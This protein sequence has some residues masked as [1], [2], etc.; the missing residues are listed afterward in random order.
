MIKHFNVYP[1]GYNKENLFEE[2]KIFLIYLMGFVPSLEDW[3][4]QMDYKIKKE[5]IKSIKSVKIDKT[6]LDLAKMQ[7]KNIVELKQK[8]LK[9]EKEK[10]LKELNKKFGI[11]EEIED[12]KI[13]GLPDIEEKPISEKERLWDILQG[14]NLIKKDG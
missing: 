10:K 9:Q 7:G 12:I 1:I 8:R 13:E 4:M 6:D 2:Q 5:D 3:T 11:E 14:K